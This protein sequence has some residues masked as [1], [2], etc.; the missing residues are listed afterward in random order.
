MRTRRQVLHRLG[1]AGVAVLLGVAL[2]L[3]AYQ[4]N[5]QPGAAV[6]RA[7]FDRHSEVTPPTDFA[8]ID[9]EVSRVDDVVVTPHGM[10]SATIDIFMPFAQGPPRPIVLWVHGGG[11]ISS[12]PETVR[13]YTVM[14]ASRGYT[15]A[16]LD[17]SLAPQARYPT[18]VIQGNAALAYLVEHATEYGG[19]SSKVFLGG[20][21]AGAQIASQLAATQTDPELAEALDISPA[22]NPPDLRGVILFCGLYDMRTVGRTGFPALRTYLWAYTSV[23]EWVDYPRIDELSTTTQVTPSY[24]PTFLTVGDADPFAP[25]TAELARRITDEGVPLATVL[26]SQTGSNLGHEYQFDFAR[27]QALFT[28]DA[29]VDFLALRS[30]T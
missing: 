26:W 28:F 30:T 6:V 5:V 19:D 1:A 27:P 8:Q 7:V 15:V 25:Q 10:P 21:S 16:S 17:Y 3:V 18:P 23:R 22:L 2:G 4:T 9:R 29:T 14:L 13:A 11:F 24:P 20:D 12:S